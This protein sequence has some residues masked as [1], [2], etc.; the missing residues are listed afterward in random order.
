MPDKV[1]S[2]LLLPAEI[3]NQIYGHVWSDN[4]VIFTVTHRPT[5]RPISDSVEL[6]A[7]EDSLSNRGVDK[8]EYTEMGR[9]R[10]E[11]R[12]LEDGPLVFIH[13]QREWNPSTQT[14]ILSTCRQTYT[15]AAGVFYGESYCCYNLWESLPDHMTNLE[16]TSDSAPADPTLWHLYEVKKPEVPMQYLAMI[17]K[18]RLVLAEKYW[19]Y[20][21]SPPAIAR[22]LRR[23]SMENVSLERLVLE[24]RFHRYMRHQFVLQPPHRMQ[25]DNGFDQNWEPPW[26]LFCRDQ[27]VAQA[28]S[29]TT[30]LKKIRVELVSC[31]HSLAKSF[32]HF[33]RSIVTTTGWACDNKRGE[34][35]DTTP[36]FGMHTDGGSFNCCWRLRPGKTRSSQPTDSL[37]PEPDLSTLSPA[38][39][40]YISEDGSSWD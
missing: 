20:L 25:S 3:R 7:T 19:H 15:E 39:D 27:S 9:P 33:I 18:L 17:R 21:T 32:P 12:I 1:P 2:F 8:D 10:Y 6:S 14:G 24:F 31:N 36:D 4:S 5:L 30:I 28:I 40:G 13:T 38:E 37:L 11:G 29:D 34:Y 23:F 16:L 26:A 22:I 35:R